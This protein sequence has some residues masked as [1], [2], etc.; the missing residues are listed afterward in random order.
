[1]LKY[2]TTLLILISLTG[3]SQM[4]TS[5]PDLERVAPTEFRTNGVE[6]TADKCQGQKV[7]IYTNNE[8]LFIK[9]ELFRLGFS[10]NSCIDMVNN[11]NENNQNIFDKWFK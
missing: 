3:C 11:F 7:Y 9:S 8:L 5:L 1:M 4:A 6:L 10:A 2:L